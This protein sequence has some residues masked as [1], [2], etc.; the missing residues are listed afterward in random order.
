MLAEQISNNILSPQKGVK[1]LLSWR[2]PK[3]G[4]D[5]HTA[6]C[7]KCSYSL[8]SILVEFNREF[9]NF[10]IIIYIQDVLGV[11]QKKEGKFKGL[12]IKKQYNGLV[13]QL[14]IDLTCFNEYNHLLCFVAG[15]DRINISNN[16]HIAQKFSSTIPEILE[17]NFIK[18]FLEE[19]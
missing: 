4:N 19:F 16:L 9:L 8:N 18:Y 15:E 6:L 2:C 7:K 3:C 12:S 11:I 14:K 13:L 17:E 10:P 1:N 5:S